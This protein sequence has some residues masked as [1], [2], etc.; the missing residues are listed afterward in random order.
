MTRRDRQLLLSP[1]QLTLALAPLTLVGVHSHVL[2]AAPVLA[3]ALPLLAGRHIGEQQPARLA[4]AF[5]VGRW[6]PTASS[7]RPRTA[8]R[9]AYRVVGRG[10]PGIGQAHRLGD[11]RWGR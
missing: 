4:A 1:A 5:V 8:R 6:R 11:A 3:L 10:C 7:C 9:T 2:T